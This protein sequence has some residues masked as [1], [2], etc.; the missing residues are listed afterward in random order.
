VYDAG[1]VAE[2]QQVGVEA[3]FWKPAN[4]YR[5]YADELPNAV[6]CSSFVA[7]VP[8]TGRW[9][10]NVAARA[11]VPD[12]SGVAGSDNEYQMR[13]YLG[14]PDL[15]AGPAGAFTPPPRRLLTQVIQWGRVLS[16]TLDPPGSVGPF[17][18]DAGFPTGFRAKNF[19]LVPGL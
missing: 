18:P 14:E 13:V 2:A 17:Q 7:T 9:W 10:I 12:A 16:D 4:Q 3:V 11:R 15:A 1:P 5:R 19:L 8:S 6:N